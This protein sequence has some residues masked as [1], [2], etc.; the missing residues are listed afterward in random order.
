MLAGIVA[1]FLAG[2][3]KEQ[4]AA[5][6]SHLMPSFRWVHIIVP[7]VATLIVAVITPAI[8]TWLWGLRSVGLVASTVLMFGV[9]SWC[10]AVLPNWTI[11]QIIIIVSIFSETMKGGL[12]LIVSGQFEA[13]PWNLGPRCGDHHPG[14]NV[15]VSTERGHAHVPL[16]AAVGLDG[17]RPYDP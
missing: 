15:S 11:L 10:V 12:R 14:G 6:R 13:E 8:L 7:V 3:V 5:S 16:S 2:H 1:A 4:F 9:I 17:K